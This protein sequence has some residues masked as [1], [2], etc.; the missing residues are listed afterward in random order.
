MLYTFSYNNKDFTAQIGQTP[1]YLQVN[2]FSGPLTR[3]Q[4]KDV[5]IAM[6]LETITVEYIPVL[7]DVHGE[8]RS[9]GTITTFT[10]TTQENWQYFYDNARSGEAIE[11]MILNGLL[12]HL[13]GITLFNPVTGEVE[14]PE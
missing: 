9:A 11:K 13:E 1:R 3:Y 12:I 2:D 10:A 8:I 7:V 14:A 4:I 6:D 5:R